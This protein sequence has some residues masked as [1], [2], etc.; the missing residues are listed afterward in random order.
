MSLMEDLKSLVSSGA[1]VQATAVVPTPEQAATPAVAPEP[2]PAVATIAP[3]PAVVVLSD[4]IPVEA[5]DEYSEDPR[6]EVIPADEVRTDL[7]KRS[8]Q[9]IVFL[10]E[11]YEA[12]NMERTMARI[13]N[14]KERH[15]TAHLQDFSQ[16]PAPAVIPGNPQLYLRSE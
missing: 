14:D 9:R 5:F 11:T 8:R 3:E 16:K 15:A 13:A 4:G 1:K 12:G 7:P 6:R 10:L 2:V